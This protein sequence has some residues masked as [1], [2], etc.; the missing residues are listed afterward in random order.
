[1]PTFD[2]PGRVALDLN[3]PAG[4]VSVG[5]WDEPRVEVEVT[6]A[7]GDDA[8]AQ[9]AAETRVEAVERGGRHE[10]SVRVP[11]RDGRLG[12]FGRSPE[13]HVAIRCP[14]GADLEL[15]T[16]SADLVARGTLG[17]VAARSASGEVRVADTAEL[18]FTTASG[19][20]VAGAVSGSLTTKSA[21]GD[22]AVR[23]VRGTAT[24]STVSGDVRLGETTGL[25]GVNTVSGDVELDAV[26]GGARV[27]CVSGDVQ[28]ATR[29]GL[30][31]WI[32][33]QSVSGS[34]ASDLEVGDAPTGAG[35]AQVELKVRTVSGDIRLTRAAPAPGTDD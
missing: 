16:Q 32:D 23:A 15:A 5:T 4:M 17:V 25:A 3:V 20:I 22:V 21:S 18:Q 34:V 8:T 1:M 14:E 27:S 2:T 11:K 26:V 28:V 6:P 9:A 30:A 24:V 33:V 10:V 13:L 35:D 19:D 12:I 31:L 7:R 29:P